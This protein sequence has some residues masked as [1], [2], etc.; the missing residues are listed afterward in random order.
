MKHLKLLSETL[1]QQGID[2]RGLEGIEARGSIN[3]QK[4]DETNKEF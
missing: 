2:N 3:H 4:R 1:E